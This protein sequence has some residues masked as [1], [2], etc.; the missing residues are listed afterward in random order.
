[1][2]SRMVG[3]APTSCVVVMCD[4]SA[5]RVLLYP[6]VGEAQGRPLVVIW[7]GFGMGA[8]YYRP[9]A[10]ELASRGFPV[11][12]GELR[13]QGSSTA[14]ASLSDR[15]GYHDLATEDYPRTIRAVKSWFDLPSDYPTVFLTH[16][17]GG[18]IA[19]LVL[20]RPEAA[21]LGLRGMMGVGTG[22]PFYRTFPKPERRRL[23]VGT[24]MMP[25]VSRLLGHWPGGPLDIT[26]YGRQSDVQLREWGRFGRRNSLDRLRG[27]DIDYMAALQKLRLPVLLT[28]FGN[29]A[30]CPSASAAALARLMPKAYP[31]VEELP[32]ELG[33][34]RW[35]REPAVVAGRFEAFIGEIGL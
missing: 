35:A 5:S 13:G 2:S 17:M 28:R 3:S 21:D 19:C 27:R 1:M 4:G 14:R 18:Q 16:S 9:I 22:T 8:H 25:L 10:A 12:V 34:N 31:H 7:P 32:G 24:V 30:D 20:A 33:H 15:W 26:N 23:R 11:A 6:A 29:D